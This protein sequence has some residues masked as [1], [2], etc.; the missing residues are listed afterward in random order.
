MYELV[1][2][3]EFNAIENIKALWANRALRQKIPPNH[4]V[5]KNPHTT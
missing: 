2:A 1:R 5:V 4:P 3:N